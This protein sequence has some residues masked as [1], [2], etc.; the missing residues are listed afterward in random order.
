[1]TVNISKPSIN[2]R[3]KL[4]ELDFAKVPFQ[5]MPAGSVVQVLLVEDSSTMTVA[6][7]TYTDTNLSLTI[8]PSS[9]SSKILAMWNVQGGLGVSG[10]GWGTRLVRVSTNVFTSASQYAQYANSATGQRQSADYKHLDSPNTTAAITYKV[11]VGTFN[12][13]SVQFNDVGNQTQ[14]VLMEI[15]G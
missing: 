1:M 15:K 14:L 10:A 12:G 11:Q 8:T 2:I 9:T 7:T 4:S 6:T 13:T 5:K 3:E